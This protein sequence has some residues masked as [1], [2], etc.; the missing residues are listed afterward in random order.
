MSR[1]KDDDRSLPQP[2]DIAQQ[3]VVV[4]RSGSVTDHFRTRIH[5]ASAKYLVSLAESRQRI[6]E[7]D[8]GTMKAR[9]DFDFERGMSGS[10]PARVE[11]AVRLRGAEVEAAVQIQNAIIDNAKADQAEAKRRAI[12]ASADLDGRL[13]E[14]SDLGRTR[15]NVQKAL[16]KQSE[17]LLAAITEAETELK[18]AKSEEAV[19]KADKKAKNALYDLQLLMDKLAVVDTPGNAA[20]KS[21][22]SPIDYLEYL[23]NWIGDDDWNEDQRIFRDVHTRL[24]TEHVKRM[25]RA[26]KSV[27]GWIELAQSLTTDNGGWIT[28]DAFKSYERIMHLIEKSQD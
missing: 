22:A 26:P 25:S 11:E 19:T 13:D 24:V 20:A 28:A 8:A 23:T 7:A 27:R 1:N 5:A 17:Y 16:L 2:I 14:K 10:I 9:N 3:P 21:S 4:R 12:N 6:A 18:A 15:A